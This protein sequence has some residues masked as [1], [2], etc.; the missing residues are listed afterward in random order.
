MR[1]PVAQSK[2]D[3]PRSKIASLDVAYGP[4]FLITAWPQGTSLCTAS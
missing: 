3:N 4:W 2:I 1:A